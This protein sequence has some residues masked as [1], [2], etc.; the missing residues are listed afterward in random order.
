MIRLDESLRPADLAPALA[1]V[2]E[3]SARKILDLEQSWNPADGAPVFTE[4]GR[5]SARGWTEWTQGFQ[6]GSAL[7]QFDATDERSFLEL[8]RERTYARMAPHVTHMGVHD[9]GFNNVST[10]GALRRLLL[11]GR[12]SGEGRELALLELGLKASG[13]V[14]ARRWTRTADAGGYIYSFNGPHSLFADTMRSLRSLALAHRLGH[15]LLEEGDRSVSLLE[16]LLLHA[17]TTGRFA[18]YRGTGRDVWDEPGRVAHES[19]FNVV[20]GNFRCPSSQQGYSPFTTWT[21]GQAWVLLG[22]AEELEFLGTLKDEELAPFGGRVDVEREMLDAVSAIAEHYLEATP[23]DGIPYWDT[24]APGL[25]RLAGHRDRP[26]DPEN[27][28]EPVDSSAAAIAA[29]GLLRLGRYLQQRAVAEAGRRFF[30]A[31]L[32]I[33]RTLAAAPYLSEDPSHQ[34]L[35]LHSVYHRPN[36]WDYVPPG[37]KIPCGESSQWGDYHL[38][39]LALLVQRLAQGKPYYVFY[40]PEPAA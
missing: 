28:L 20:D 27:D 40:G 17:R 6:F 22:F 1:R 25:A 30:Q 2:F 11:E 35:L 21:R 29:Q 10:W 16:R 37:R 9:H 32:T 7:L 5:Y 18:V 36:G 3:L 4:R 34:G 31:G 15:A 23:S 24:G 33:T 8:G 39:E 13:A 19:V 26:A 38:R 14:Q 12:Y